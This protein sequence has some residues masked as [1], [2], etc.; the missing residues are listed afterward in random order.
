MIR[1]QL[2]LQLRPVRRHSELYVSL[3]SDSCAVHVMLPR[4]NAYELLMRGS[5]YDVELNTD[6]SENL[7]ALDTAAAF[8][9]NPPTVLER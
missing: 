2:S 3:N 9:R 1:S 7:L 6:D 5:T 8:Q 4:R